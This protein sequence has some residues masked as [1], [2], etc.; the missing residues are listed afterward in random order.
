MTTYFD[1]ATDTGGEDEDWYGGRIVYCDGTR[2]LSCLDL[3]DQ[4]LIRL[5]QM[6][7]T[8]LETER[9]LYGLKGNLLR[10]HGSRCR[11]GQRCCCLNGSHRVHGARHRHPAAGPATDI[12]CRHPTG[13]CSERSSRAPDA[14]IVQGGWASGIPNILL[15]QLDRKNSRRQ[16]E[17]RLEGLA[18]Q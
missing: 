1:L 16:R 10:R 11:L 3:L 14:R 4:R 6:T 5:E 18:A 9:R 15:T 13:D 7:E 17:R 12:P 8:E 2:C